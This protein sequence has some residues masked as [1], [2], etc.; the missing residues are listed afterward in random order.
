MFREGVNGLCA[1]EIFGAYFSYKLLFLC[2]EVST[3]AESL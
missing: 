1:L 2:S 3:Y